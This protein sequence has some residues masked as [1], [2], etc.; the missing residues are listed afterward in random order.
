MSEQRSVE[1]AI[2]QLERRLEVR[3]GRLARHVE[4]LESAARERARPLPFVGIAV[5]A[6]AG[7]AIARSQFTRPPRLRYTRS[8]A[9]RTGI[10]AGLLTA[11]QLALRIA[12]NPLVRRGWAAFRRQPPRV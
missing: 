6:I 3:R 11:L 4:E 10:L 9:T 12:G 1:H 5:F 8:A 7:F 2:D